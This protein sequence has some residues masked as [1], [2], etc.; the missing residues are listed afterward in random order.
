M[1]LVKLILELSA[2]TVIFLFLRKSLLRNSPFTNVVNSEA[3]KAELRREQS[4]H[5]FLFVITGLILSTASF[6][7]IYLFFG[8]AHSL[9]NYEGVL[10]VKQTALV[11]PSLIIGFYISTF[12]AKNI[13]AQFVGI[14]KSAFLEHLLTPQKTHKATFQAVFSTLALVPAIVL[15]SLQFNVYLKTDGSKIY[16]KQMFQDEKVYSLAEVS[17][18][19]GGSSNSFDIYLNNGDKISTSGYSGNLNYFLDNITR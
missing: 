8:I 14:N 6:W 3:E 1:F 18:I 16:T 11:I 10:V 13:Y 2:L 5:S 19:G 4:T 17:K 7:L 12:W 15:L 9:G